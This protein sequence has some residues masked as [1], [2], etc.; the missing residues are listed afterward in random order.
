VERGEIVAILGANG[1]GKT[2]LL[3]AIS[4][5]LRPQSGHI[6]FEGRATAGCAAE[7]LVS[8]GISHVPERRQIFAT[9]SV[10]DNLR[11]GAYHRHRNDWRAD[12]EFVFRLFPILAQRKTQDG[13]T[14]SGGEQQMLA[15]A[16]GLMSK[17][18]LLLLDEPS[19][20]LA[21]LI[22]KELMRVI[23]EL[24]QQGLTVMLVEQNARAALK[25]ADRGYVLETGRVVLEG[26]AV[27]LMANPEVQHAYLG[28]V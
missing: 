15:I 8:W 10:L 13:G 24:R 16:R 2:T 12:L 28:S 20:G 1:A 4:G 9:M 18:Q 22:V 6:S 17:P 3:N 23:A 7:Q 25:I 14:L 11:L 21:P 27:E 5:L 19:L 26:K